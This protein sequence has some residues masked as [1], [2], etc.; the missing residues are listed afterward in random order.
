MTKTRTFESLWRSSVID[1][2]R[3]CSST[4]HFDGWIA[5]FEIWSIDADDPV[6]VEESH[7]LLDQEDVQ[8]QYEGFK[9]HNNIIENQVNGGIH[10][11]LQFPTSI[12]ENLQTFTVLTTVFRRL[13]S[14]PTCK[15]SATSLS[16]TEIWQAIAVPLRETIHAPML[17]GLSSSTSNVK[18]DA[19]MFS[20]GSSPKSANASWSEHTPMYRL[21]TRRKYVLY[22][23]NEGCG[24]TNET[25][26]MI[27]TISVYQINNH[28]TSSTSVEHLGCIESN[29]YFGSMQHAVL[30]P[31]LPLLAFH[32]VSKQYIS[33]IVLWKFHDSTSS[34]PQMI[35]LHH[36]LIRASRLGGDQ[37]LEVIIS[38]NWTLKYLQFSACG[39][40]IVYQQQGASYP[41]IK[42]ISELS[43]YKTATAHTGTTMES[44]SNDAQ[45]MDSTKEGIPSTSVSTKGTNTSLQT[46]ST[47]EPSLLTNGVVSKLSFDPSTRRELSVVHCQNGVDLKQ[48]LLSLPAWRDVQHVSASVRLS[49]SKRDDKI[50]IVLNKTAKPFYEL[51]DDTEHTLPAV[52]RKDSRAIPPPRRPSNA[53]IRG[54]SDL[55]RRYMQAIEEKNTQREKRRRLD[56]V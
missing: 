34:V 22:Q 10:L 36:E 51:R 39:T 48:P 50:T 47:N 16:M 17:K 32:F 52:V 26:S 25:G 38:S 12:E 5:Q 37:S 29:G 14:L 46:F 28:E 8:R 54:T 4:G 9:K 44:L 3:P 24:M 27:G 55:R 20:E 56:G 31:H 49:T 35:I 7:V 45:S 53:A 11:A 15:D 23:S 41:V 1:Q 6:V 2:T 19:P 33:S 18:S 30:H 43:V 42:S 21:T 13:K 40:N